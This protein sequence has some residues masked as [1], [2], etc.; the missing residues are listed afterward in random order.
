MKTTVTLPDV[1]ADMLRYLTEVIATAEDAKK[2]DKRFISCCLAFDDDK[3]TEITI[4][5]LEFR[6]IDLFG[7]I[8]E[9]L[10]ELAKLIPDDCEKEKK[11]I[12]NVTNQL[13]AMFAQSMRDIVTS[14]MN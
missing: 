11:I 7:V 10:A 3:N 6:S 9:L 12:K 14:K 2:Y 13:D 5:T 1:S 4:S 8:I